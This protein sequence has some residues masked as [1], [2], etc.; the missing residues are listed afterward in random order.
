MLSYK[1]R[2]NASTTE[3]AFLELEKDWW[4]EVLNDTV[5]VEIVTGNSELMFTFLMH[6]HVG[7]NLSCPSNNSTGSCI[8]RPPVRLKKK[9]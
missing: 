6:A 5:K 3:R 4:F 1:I 9:A 8:L 7:W 2:N